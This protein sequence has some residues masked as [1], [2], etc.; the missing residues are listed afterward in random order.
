MSREK[1]NFYKNNLKKLREVNC[2]GMSRSEFARRLGFKTG[3]QIITWENGNGRPK[4]NMMI[5]IAQLLNCQVHDI[6]TETTEE[7]KQRIEEYIKIHKNEK[8]NLTSDNRNGIMNINNSLTNIINMLKIYNERG[9]MTEI[10][11]RST[12]IPITPEFIM[13]MTGDITLNTN[14]AISERIFLMRCILQH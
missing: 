9:E 12:A 8:N 7:E 11:A 5:Q 10:D 6:W 14:E 4:I 2:A 3:Q 1:N 13:N